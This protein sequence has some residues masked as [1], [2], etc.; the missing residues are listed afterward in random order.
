MADT[1]YHCNRWIPT[2]EEFRIPNY[3]QTGDFAFV[4]RAKCPNCSHQAYAYCLQYAG[5][6]HVTEWFQAP[7]T[8]ARL[9]NSRINSGE[10]EWIQR[11]DKDHK[12]TKAGQYAGEYSMKIRGAADNVL[13]YL[14]RLD[15]ASMINAS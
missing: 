1:I 13:A 14:H 15:K 2:A 6:S 10:V 3:P 9:F 5:L 7:K 12:S 4:K 8:T 11:L